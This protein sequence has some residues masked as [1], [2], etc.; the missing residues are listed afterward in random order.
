MPPLA[1][2][3]AW[4][5]GLADRVLAV[6]GAFLFSQA[7]EFFQQY[8]QRLGG[9]LDEA[10]RILAQF[11]HTADQAG[12]TLDRFITQTSANAD[13]AVARLA[14]VMSDA[15]ARVQHLEAA[16]T[17][18][19]DASAWTRPFAFLRHLDGSI[20]RATWS[21]YRPAVPTTLEGLV[22]AAAGMLL[23]VSLYHLLVR[24]FLRPPAQP[25]PK[26]LP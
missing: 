16:Y 23:F 2:L 1:R 4:L 22:Y 5:D 8:L 7:P 14:Q 21:D 15:L 9:R 26:V 19:R 6:A 18:L 24:R 10:R 3:R 25:T 11:E 13:T 20:A 17:S 12:L